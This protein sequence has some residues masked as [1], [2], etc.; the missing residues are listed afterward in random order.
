MPSPTLPAHAFADENSVRSYDPQ[1]AFLGYQCSLVQLGV[2]NGKSVMATQAGWEAPDFDFL[3]HLPYEPT[4]QE[5]L[6]DLGYNIQVATP[7]S[8]GT[9]LSSA[10]TDADDV[11][12]SQDTNIQEERKKRPPAKRKRGLKRARPEHKVVKQRG[13]SQLAIFISNKSGWCKGASHDANVPAE[14]LCATTN[15]AFFIA[16]YS[17]QAADPP[18]QSGSQEV[19]FV[20]LPRSVIP[21]TC[22]GMFEKRSQPWKQR[23]KIW[24]DRDSKLT[25]LK[26]YFPSGKTG[27]S[28]RDVYLVAS[29]GALQGVT[30]SFS[31]ETRA[32]LV[33]R[34]HT[35]T[36]EFRR[37]IY[38]VDE[39]PRF[40]KSVIT[41]MLHCCMQLGSNGKCVPLRA[42]VLKIELANILT[43]EDSLWPSSC[44]KEIS[45]G[46]GVRGLLTLLQTPTPIPQWAGPISRKVLKVAMA[47]RKPLALELCT[48]QHLADIDPAEAHLKCIGGICSCSDRKPDFFKKRIRHLCNCCGETTIYHV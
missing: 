13:K 43:D 24:A 19:G 25:L 41:P 35:F 15:M 26:A 22:Q 21:T 47:L 12:V 2:D 31:E 38:A 18:R 14:L 36:N 29:P 16:V 33:G 32:T 48:R 28:R 42:E 46:R 44:M 30:A 45:S 3:P 34:L 39:S 17:R 23:R 40:S 1:L 4:L 27:A 20:K 8:I 5:A 6:E 37:F 9:G 7:T 11:L 10:S